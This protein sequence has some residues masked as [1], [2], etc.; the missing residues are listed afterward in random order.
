MSSENSLLNHP[1]PLVAVSLSA[2]SFNGLLLVGLSFIEPIN[3]HYIGPD[4]DDN[5]RSSSSSFT[6]CPS[7]N[8]ISDLTSRLWSLSVPTIYPIVHPSARSFVIPPVIQSPPLIF[9]PIKESSPSRCRRRD[10]PL[11]CSS[12][13]T[14]STISFLF[15]HL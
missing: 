6:S 2:L 4:D 13:A 9:A 7:K 10:W 3:S 8:I 15:P 1:I 14:C 11:K 5:N 12:I